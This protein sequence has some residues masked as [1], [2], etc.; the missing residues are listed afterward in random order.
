MLIAVINQNVSGLIQENF[1][2]F[3]LKIQNRYSYMADGS[4]RD[5]S[6]SGSFHLVALL[7]LTCGFQGHSRR[8]ENAENHT[9]E[10]ILGQ[11]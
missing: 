2:A 4:P 5:D 8:R 6:D 3:S 11:T 7:S 1:I 9:W 10:V